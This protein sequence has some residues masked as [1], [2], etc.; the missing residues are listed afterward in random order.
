[1]IEY[2]HINYIKLVMVH[3]WSECTYILAERDLSK[4]ILGEESDKKI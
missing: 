3:L 2:T 1:M 4:R